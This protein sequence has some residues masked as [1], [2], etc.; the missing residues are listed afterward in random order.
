MATN[1]HKS[2]AAVL[3]IFSYAFAF[4]QAPEAKLKQL[5]DHR[6]WFELRDAV[7]GQ[8]APPLYLGAAASAFNR[9]EEAEK[10]L[11]QVIRQ[12]PMSNDAKEARE[13]LTYLYMRLGRSADVSKQIE[14][15]LKS[16]PD[17]ADLQNTRTIFGAFSDSSNLEIRLRSNATFDCEVKKDGVHLPILVNG[18]SVTWL[19]DTGANISVLSDAEAARLEVAGPAAQGRANDLA[20]GAATVGTAVI[21][22]MMIA[23]SELRN[24]PV[25]VLPASQPPWA[26]LPAGRQGAIGLPVAIALRMLGWTSAS[27]CHIDTRATRQPTAPNVAFDGLQTVNRVSFEGA[28]LDFVL[29]TGNQQETQLWQRFGRE[30]PTL[31]ARG[32]SDVRRVT[33]VGGANDREVTILP[34]MRLQ[35]GGLETTLEPAILFS[36]PVG[37]DRHH[38]NLGMDI[39]SQ[40]SE[41]SIDFRAMSLMLR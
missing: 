11:A 41:V 21:R 31:V 24:V 25:I 2:T 23:G 19:L 33:Q 30:F 13:L 39:L 7:K 4:A 32:H 27:V 8:N 3:A 16:E 38:G 37:D 40:A 17:R 22:R 36:R 26:D 15:Q 9:V 20:G 14:E 1:L 5:Y 34:G 35:V 28:S 6:Q 10:R 12:A 18:H 29:D